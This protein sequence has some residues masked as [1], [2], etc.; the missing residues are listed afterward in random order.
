MVRN[1]RKRSGVRLVD[2][3]AL[4]WAPRCGL[5]VGLPVWSRATDRVV[6]DEN[7]GGAGAGLFWS[8]S[9]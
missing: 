6:E 5:G 2:V 8:F 7:T 4:N 3:N 1:T 9:L